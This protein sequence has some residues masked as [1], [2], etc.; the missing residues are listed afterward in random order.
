MPMSLPI[1]FCSLPSQFFSAW[2]CSSSAYMCLYPQINFF[3]CLLV[4]NLCWSRFFGY[5]SKD[6]RTL[7][8]LFVT[9]SFSARM[10]TVTLLISSPY[11]SYHVPY[12]RLSDS[13]GPTWYLRPLFNIIRRVFMFLS[14]TSFYI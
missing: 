6:Q 10:S 4:S 1:R 2:S 8:Y 13:P 5:F 11:C 14:F 12:R 3:R 9:Y 7:M